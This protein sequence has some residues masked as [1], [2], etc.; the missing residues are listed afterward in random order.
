MIKSDHLAF[1]PLSNLLLTFSKRLVSFLITESMILWLNMKTESL[2]IYEIIFGE[3]CLDLKAPFDKF[4]GS[5]FRLFLVVAGILPTTGKNMSV[6]SI[7]C[8]VGLGLPM[9][10]FCFLSLRVISF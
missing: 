10:A 8:L 6:G 4:R 7:R 5:S 1:F 3:V 9:D 2:S